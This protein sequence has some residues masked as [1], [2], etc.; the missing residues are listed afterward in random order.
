MLGFDIHY[1]SISY[2]GCLQDHMDTVS[3]LQFGYLDLVKPVDQVK[4]DSQG[5]DSK[6]NLVYI[7]SR[8]TQDCG[9]S[10]ES[11]SPVL[12]ISDYYHFIIGQMIKIL[13]QLAVYWV[14]LEQCSV[15]GGMSSHLYHSSM[16][17]DLPDQSVCPRFHSRQRYGG[18]IVFQGLYLQK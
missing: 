4:H 5:S 11:L 13:L 16:S 18:F 1:W 9:F 7:C 10:F 3:H 8:H 15:P 6:C 14:P 17:L 12:L 2:L